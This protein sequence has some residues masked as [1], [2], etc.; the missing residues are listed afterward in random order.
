[1]NKLLHILIF[2][3]T[4]L[5]GSVAFASD[6]SSDA[7][8][9]WLMRMSQ[10]MQNESYTGTYVY[11][12]GG[13]IETL[14]LQHYR[15]ETGNYERLV[16]LN[17]EAREIIRDNSHVTCIW[18][19]SKSVIVSRSTPSTPFAEWVEGRVDEFKK[20]YEMSVLG[21]ERIAGR[22]ATVIGILP[23]DGMRYGHKIWI[24]SE[25]SL[26]LGSQMFDLKGGVVEQV[27]FTQMQLTQS[28]HAAQ[29]VPSITDPSYQWQQPVEPLE[30]VDFAVDWV[31]SE[32]PVGFAQ[33]SEAIKP[34]GE[35]NTPTH[36]VTLSDG[37]ASVS[38]YIE[39][40]TT[41]SPEALV[42]ESQMGAMSAFG[43]KVA[44]F[45]VTVVGEVPM[46]TAAAIGQSVAI[47]GES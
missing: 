45:H 37:L 42:G 36:H 9:T 47:A 26:L 6:D 18:P 38:V 11:L 22:L 20:W 41:G 43:R 23:R 32:L 33:V 46:S 16:S 13:K 2:S 34:M 7:G 24:D 30:N 10:A 39:E 27:L 44:N 25:N 31:F 3:A 15:S 5:F 14:Q 29:F 40:I 21:E 35:H 28:F 19:G 4:L 1:M 17:G 12:H 8:M